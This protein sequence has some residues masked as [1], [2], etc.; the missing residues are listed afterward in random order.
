[1]IGGAVCVVKRGREME[2]GAMGRGGAGRAEPGKLRGR[3]AGR[4]NYTISG[5]VAA[6]PLIPASH[7]QRRPRRQQR[8]NPPR[9]SGPQV[10]TWGVADG[11]LQIADVEIL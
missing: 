6:A 10:G 3:E 11:F 4:A 2:A 5:V 1:M 8:L 7:S 9:L